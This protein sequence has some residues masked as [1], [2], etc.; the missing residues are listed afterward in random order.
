[1]MSAAS[2]HEKFLSHLDESESA[3]ARAA[4]WLERLGEKTWIPKTT[5]A[6]CHADWKSHADNGD[7]YLLRRI[8]VKHLSVDFT[9]E[10][11][12]PY[13]PKF[14]VCAKHAWDRAEQKPW[15]FITFNQAMTHA[16][17]IEGAANRPW[18]VETR[19]DS[20]YS[21]PEASQDFYFCP[22]R[23]VRWCVV[24]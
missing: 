14:I 3:V 18:F 11:D 16:A 12:W 2:N 17:V 24:R 20:R 4:S 9:C 8:E 1:M 19:T 7:L 15:R 6:K 21:G 23:L 10:N 22:M 13:K 5:K